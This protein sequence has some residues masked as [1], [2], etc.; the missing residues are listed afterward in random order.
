M[1]LIDD[2]M[3]A[4]YYSP[5]NLKAITV[6]FFALS[7]SACAHRPTTTSSEPLLEDGALNQSISTEIKK[8]PI[9]SNKNSSIKNTPETASAVA[10]LDLLQRIRQGFQF[11]ELSSRVVRKQEHWNATHETFLNNLFDRATPFL[12]HIVEEID[13][14]GLPMELALLP[15]IESSFKPD[16]LSRSA[17]SGLWQFIPATG[18]EFGLRQDWWYDG[19]RDA[20]ASTTAA[21]DYL[22]RLNQ[23]YNGD[24]FL[25]L[26]AYNAG[27]G[28]VSRAIKANKKRGK[29]TRYQDLNLRL[30]TRRYVPK[31]IALKNIINNPQKHGVKLPLIPNEPHFK[32]VALKGQIDLQKF[33]HDAGI[34]RAELK[35]L[36]AGFKRWATSPKGPHRLLI[37]INVNGD[38]KHAEIAAQ[39]TQAIDYHKHRI[40]KGESLSGIAR[41]YDV[42]ISALRTSNKLNGSFIRAGNDLIVPVKLLASNNLRMQSIRPAA[43]NPNVHAVK[44]G[45]TLW[46][47]SRN[48]NINLS[49]LIAWN[50]LAEN[51]ILRLNQLI[52]LIQN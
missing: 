7:I 29:G 10:N 46:S 1:S 4:H 14:R 39:L 18:R 15:A 50:N 33:A 5:M 52:K 6:I 19:R 36:N 43:N 30:E 28:T 26:A 3:Q 21:L 44:K 8:A 22:T 11:P 23:R 20:L 48:Y 51:Q 47:I 13:K 31:L 42:S 16:A 25:T 2:T 35:H 38:I 9:S 27:P 37:P 40:K 17:A 12:F 41:K 45:D 34:G 24:W 49:N 32:V